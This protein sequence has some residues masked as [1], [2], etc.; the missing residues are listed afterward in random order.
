MKSILFF[1]ILIL[2]VP[3]S[4]IS[5]TLHV[6]AE[7]ATIQGALQAAAPGDT[8]LVAPG[9][10]VEDIAF[11]NKSVTL[12][13]EEGPEATVIDESEWPSSY[14]PV[15]RFDDVTASNAVL[16][17]FTLMNGEGVA[18]V[19]GSMS[20]DYYGG[21]IYCKN[22][23]P[24]I[25]N[26]IIRDNSA[27]GYFYGTGQGGG[28]YCKNASPTLINNRIVSNIAS[29][30]GG[31]VY[32]TE[33]SATLFHNNLIAYNEGHVGAGFYI[34]GTSS[35]EITSCTITVNDPSSHAGGIGGQTGGTV[36]LMNSIVWGNY[37]SDISAY[38]TVGAAYCDIG[39]VWP[40]TG[41]I[42]ADP[43]FV[44]ATTLNW[45]LQQDPC[46][47]GVVNPC[48]DTGNPLTPQ[49]S[50]T[51]RTDGF[52]DSGVVDM[53]YHYHHYLLVPGEYAAIQTAIDAAVDGD[54]VLVDAGTF[55]ENIDFLGKGIV[56]E[57]TGGAAVTVID[58]GRAGSVITL[59]K[60]EDEFTRLRGFTLTNGT[61]AAEPNP[62][63]GGITCIGS[64]PRIED[65]VIESNQASY[66]GGGIYCAGK[67]SPLEAGPRIEGN[68]IQDN[69]AEKYGGGIF[70]IDCDPEIR[71]NFVSQNECLHFGSMGGG[72]ACWDASPRI[73]GNEIAGNHVELYGAGVCCWFAGIE[74]DSNLLHD[75]DAGDTGGAVA[76]LHSDPVLVNNVMYANTAGVHGG[77]V[78][79]TNSSIP[80]V[81]N[82]TLHENQAGASGGGLF[83]H[84]ST[85]TLC[86]TI[87]WNNASPSSPQI[88][89]TG[90]TVSYC[91]IQDGFPGTGNINEDPL[92]A[93]PGSGNF[94]I[95]LESPCLDAGLLL[96]P[97]LPDL[98]F[99]GDPRV[100]YK[101]PD[102]GADEY[103]LG[104]KILHVPADYPMIQDAID[105]SV[106]GD[107]IQVAPGTYFENLRIEY[108]DI[109]LKST[110]GPEVTVIDGS[111]GY[112]QSAVVDFWNGITPNC[113]L[114]G[115]TITNAY[116][117]SKFGGGILCYENSSPTI[118]NN[119]VCFNKAA[120]GGGIGCTDASSPKIEGNIICNNIADGSKGEGGGIAWW[121]DCN[122]LITNNLIQDNYS[123]YFGGGIY[124]RSG[125]DTYL[126][127]NVIC[128]NEAGL[129]GGGIAT[130]GGSVRIVNCT[131]FNNTAVQG[132]GIYCE[133]PSSTHAS[134]SILWGNQ[135]TTGKEIYLIG[136]HWL[137]SLNISYSDVEGGS[138]SAYVGPNATL[139]WG[140]GMIDS[141]PLFVDAGGG[142]FHIRHDSPCRNAGD[143][144]LMGLPDLDYEGDP[145]M[146]HGTVDIGPDE[147]YTHLYV[148][149][150]KTPGGSIQGKFIGLP[151]TTPV[152]LFIG[153]GVLPTP[154]NTMWG[155]YWLQA[156]WFLFNLLPIPGN[157]ILELPTT[158]PGSIP[159]PY[160][161]PM[162]SIIG[163]NADS[164]TNLCV[165]EVR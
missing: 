15:V 158:L 86:N 39:E 83:S 16:D 96:V 149:G 27:I 11:P 49:F 53:G 139:D 154:A 68:T 155:E 142:D 12:K 40:G 133:D 143:N 126:L 110:D 131:L 31:A 151:G 7:Y 56:L 42:M 157:G 23:S 160:D 61:G 106:A 47:P 8:V 79:A 14:K 62:S 101:A 147:F 13:S 164:L 64:A 99:E 6:P 9:I 35:A 163:L 117:K 128:G 21:G 76:C 80:V 124:G 103:N 2:T 1:S 54:K 98:D 123:N 45:R 90:L 84:D 152:G 140:D 141:D 134:N 113:V 111:P 5:K 122:P 161:V 46:Q 107:I 95:E 97:S 81:T 104:G 109:T 145:R 120:V 87:L 153:S 70:I 78:S 65:N 132:G 63:G 135:A 44:D 121:P 116:H 105:D 17:G 66:A 130:G 67:L 33:N 162:Q 38:G 36:T 43:L 52:Q 22:S 88:A 112:E 89:G 41:N 73:F 94:R 29:G 136:G 24:L 69:E 74:L 37:H 30:Y 26:C 148:T 85:V 91:D 159:A 114:E 55:F 71:G 165:L 92:F 77:G 100:V 118:R 127:N 59:T 3:A 108:D 57:S 156:P 20:I 72:I 125:G 50:G 58:G 51:T 137:C 28:I 18:K 138:G 60:G 19:W 93:D 119:I 150:D 144:A 48:V 129:N 82:N 32:C 34:D 10:Y 25:M 146:A 4:A 75:N 115:F 102:M